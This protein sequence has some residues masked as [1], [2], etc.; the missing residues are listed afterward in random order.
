M[1]TFMRCVGYWDQKVKK[2]GILEVKMAQG[3]AI[4]AA[5]IVAKLFPQILGLSVWWF[6]ALIVICGLE[7]HYVLWLKE[8]SPPGV[9]GNKSTPC[10]SEAT[11]ASPGA[12]SR[13]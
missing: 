12:G 3:A 7:V 6:V 13:R 10:H 11:Q 4:G 1:N 5:F 9:T 8:D 2:F